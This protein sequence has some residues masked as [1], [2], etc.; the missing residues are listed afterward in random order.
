M[1]TI[2]RSKID[3]ALEKVAL[4]HLLL[5]SK[6]EYASVI[7]AMLQVCATDFAW[8]PELSER[9]YQ[10]GTEGFINGME[11]GNGYQSE[12]KV[13]FTLLDTP[14]RVELVIQDQ[15]KG[16]NPETL[17]DP[18]APEN[19]LKDSGRGIFLIRYWADDVQF[20]DDGRRLIL[21]FFKTV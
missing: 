7:L 5:A 10:A 13:T 11:H 6:A 19:L 4:V 15:G 8:P 21:Q 18:L 9:I 1:N 2:P 3:P 16:F 20:E 17:P 14:H 12:K